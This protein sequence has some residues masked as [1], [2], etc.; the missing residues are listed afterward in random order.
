[1]TLISI[2]QVEK[3][4]KELNRPAIKALHEKM[5]TYEQKKIDEAE[6][7]K[8]LNTQYCV[9]CSKETNWMKLKNNEAICP[10]CHMLVGERIATDS[11]LNKW[12]NLLADLNALENVYVLRIT[13]K[14]WGGDIYIRILRKDGN[15]EVEIFREVISK[16][17]VSAWGRNS[18]YAL[19]I[20]SSNYIHNANRLKK[21]FGVNGLAKGLHKKCTEI[22][23]AIKTEKEE[24]IKEANAKKSASTLILEN[25]G[26]AEY[27]QGR[28]AKMMA[29]DEY[30]ITN[31]SFIYKGIGF[32]SHNGED[33]NVSIRRSLT[34][35]Q[36]K[37]LG[38]F[39][40]ELMK[41]EK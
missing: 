40:E 20:S 31:C 13:E 24:R 17:A 29:E 15:E 4:V 21:D 9:V 5:L 34:A 28:T 37:K 36:T 26:D 6:Y 25:F 38:D 39:M 19:R 35:E 33:Y 7:I 27:Y 18:T 30:D 23:T 16:S 3:A 41:E 14:S 12:Y 22:F 32:K 11:L 2:E 1:M 10:E 8:A